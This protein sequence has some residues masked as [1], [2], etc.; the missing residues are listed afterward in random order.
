VN[1][2]PNT[3]DLTPAVGLYT[4][5]LPD[6]LE[7]VVTVRVDA[8][9]DN[10]IYS[11]RFRDTTNKWRVDRF[12]PP[13]EAQ[14]DTRQFPDGYFKFYASVI[15]TAGNYTKLGDR[16]VTIANGALPSAELSDIPPV[17]VCPAGDIGYKGTI[18]DTNGNPMANKGV[19]LQIYAGQ[20]GNLK[21]CDPTK[22]VE[23]WLNYKA[24]STT[25][26]T[27]GDFE[28]LLPVSGK[29]EMW[30]QIHG[31]DMGRAYILSA[32]TDADG[33]V[34]LEDAMYF[35]TQGTMDD[36]VALTRHIKEGHI[37]Q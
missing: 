11:V 13:Y 32:D 17:R 12:T 1:V 21:I 18:R 24:W 26:D 20:D 14:L 23:D 4:D 34:G 2:G 22:P 3:P 31:Q 7:G 9:D 29:G 10:G 6:V 37:C 30:V 33:S 27:N 16:Q 28:F 25:T 15:D 5:N 8:V 35:A 36:L 19:F